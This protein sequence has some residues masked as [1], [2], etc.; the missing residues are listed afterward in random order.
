MTQVPVCVE[1]T[2]EMRIPRIVTIPERS[3]GGS[4]MPLL[5]CPCCG[6]RTLR[7]VRCW[8]IC[9]ICFWEDDPLQ[10]DEPAYAGGANDESLDEAR[11]NFQ[12]FGAAS[13][14]VLPYTRPPAPDEERVG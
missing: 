4:R 7:E 11:R 9:P 12:E 8:E 3:V 10:S 6:Y 2:S 1:W 5:P 14:S 13:R